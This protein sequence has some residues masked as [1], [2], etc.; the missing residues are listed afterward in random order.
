MVYKMGSNKRRGEPEEPLASSVD[1]F[2]EF[3]N[4]PSLTGSTTHTILMFLLAITVLR[5]INK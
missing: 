1:N 5:R 3:F 4:P 2:G